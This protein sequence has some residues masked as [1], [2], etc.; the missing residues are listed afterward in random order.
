MAW[1]DLVSGRASS[2]AAL[3]V[4]H[5]TRIKG[6]VSREAARGLAD[7]H[8]TTALAQAGLLKLGDR[9]VALTSAG[10]KHHEE[11][12]DAYRAE[13]DVVTVAATYERFL[14]LNAPV[15]SACARWQRSDR[16]PEALFHVTEQLGGYLRRLGPALARAAQVA[17]WFH[18]YRLRLSESWQRAVDG[19][20]RYITDPQVDSFHTIW[21]ECHEDYLL[22][23]G[24]RRDDEET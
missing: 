2:T 22:T 17:P 24:R 14:A 18:Q 7:D 12:L 19:D 16:G 11:L 3:A 6:V 8:V 13:T 4:L 23:L 1:S 5:A 15:K 20:E 10:L 9:G 21:F